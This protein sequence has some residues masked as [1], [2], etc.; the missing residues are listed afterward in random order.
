MPRVGAIDAH[1]HDPGLEELVFQHGTDDLVEGLAFGRVAPVS[2]LERNPAPGT[3]KLAQ[4]VEDR[5][6]KK[7]FFYMKRTEEKQGD[8][9]PRELKY[10]SI[11]D[12]PVFY[13]YHYT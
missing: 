7:I 6:K 9:S 12:Q 11:V 2:A 13:F 10:A 8:K 3:V 5:W 4:N 1:G